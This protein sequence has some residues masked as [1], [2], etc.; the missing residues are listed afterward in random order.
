MKSAPYLAALLVALGAPAARS[1]PFDVLGWKCCE[2]CPW[3]RWWCCC[4]DDYCP[5]PC[6][7]VPPLPCF[8]CDDYCPKPLPP[9]PPW[10]RCGSCDDYFPKPRC[11]WTEIG[12]GP[13]YQCGPPGCC[14]PCSERKP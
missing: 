5:K 10:V 2:R 7:P 9:C 14:G 6:P 13:S 3:P 8:G 1:A 11:I 12:S 4:P